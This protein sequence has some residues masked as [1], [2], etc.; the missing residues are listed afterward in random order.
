M[1]FPTIHSHL[2]L[3]RVAPITLGT[4]TTG[5]ERISASKL[6]S[7][8]NL[9]SSP[10][11]GG[12]RIHPRLCSSPQFIPIS[13]CDPWLWRGINA[14][15]S[16]HVARAV[17]LITLGTPTPG[18]ERISASKLIKIGPPR[19]LVLIRNYIFRSVELR[20]PRLGGT[21]VVPDNGN[22][23]VRS[24]G[25]N[26]LANKIGTIDRQTRVLGPFI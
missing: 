22:P 16:I 20:N 2:R 24:R 14:V 7:S 17:L 9:N 15:P 11:P 10:R 4:P 21:C 26:H 23:T 3:R 13:G 1:Q 8:T 18:P 19:N 12:D 6:I 5:P 25:Y